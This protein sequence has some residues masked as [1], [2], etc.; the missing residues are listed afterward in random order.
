LT[1]RGA[2]TPGRG[3]CEK[4]GSANIKIGH[5]TTPANPAAIFDIV[6]FLFD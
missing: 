4:L 1:G 6:F 5:K 3:V 2:E